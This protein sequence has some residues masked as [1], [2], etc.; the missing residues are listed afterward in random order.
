M[1]E[2]FDESVRDAV[3]SSFCDLTS[4]AT[5]FYDWLES[6]TSAVP[7]NETLFTIPRTAISGATGLFCNRAPSAPPLPPAPQFTGGQCVGD[8]YNVI[9]TYDQFFNGNFALTRVDQAGSQLFTGPIEE[10]FLTAGGQD[11]FVRHNNGQ[12]TD[13]LSGST[14]SVT[15]ANIRDVRVENVTNPSDPCGDLSG[16]N[17]NPT[18]PGVG[19]PINVDIVFGPPGSEINIPVDLTFGGPLVGVGG[20]IIVPFGIANVDF[21]LTGEL[22]LTT[23]DIVLNFGGRSGSSE[24]CCLPEDIDDTDRPEDGGDDNDETEEQIVGVVVNGTVDDSVIRSTKVGQVNGPDFYNPRI[25]NIYFKLKL[26]TLIVWTNPIAV[27]H[28]N[29]YIECPAS[30]GAIGV[31]GNPVQGVT[32][33]LQPVR[34]RIPTDD[35]I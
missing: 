20:A 15:Y 19:S 2:L 32:L 21:N 22:S 7:N 28:P 17:P 25:A 12:E 10:V 31:V 1:A 9:A 16:Q 3:R 29:Q 26:R 5:D 34:R 30:F 35:S 27:K 24:P 18:P 23:G 11:V 8:Q 13:H 33:R 6:A 14:S 4:V